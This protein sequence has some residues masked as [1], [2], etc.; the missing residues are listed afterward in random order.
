MSTDINAFID[1]IIAD[2]EKKVRTDLK[3]ISQVA[4]ND[5]VTKAKEVVMLYYSHY[6]KPPRIYERTNNLR[7]NVINSDLSFIALN[8]NGYDAWVQ[9]SSDNMSDYEMGNKDVV[10]ANFMHGIHGRESIYV[11]ENPAMGLME[12]FQNNYKKILDG[13]FINLGYK[14]K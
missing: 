12:E 2:A 5:F 14:V 7:N 9:F 10:V 6:P 11:E 1:K 13:Y 4:K 8:G 3:N